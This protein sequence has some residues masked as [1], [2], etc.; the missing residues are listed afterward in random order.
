V[1]HADL[2]QRLRAYADGTLDDAEAELVRVHLATGCPECLREVFTRPVGLPRPAVVVRRSLQGIVVAALAAAAAVGAAAGLLMG[3]R[4][5]PREVADGR[6]GPLTSEVDRLRAE[7][8]H[9]EAAARACADKQAPGKEA[10]DEDA[11]ARKDPDPTPAPSPSDVA[12]STHA[13]ASCPPA[14]CPPPA[15]EGTDEAEAGAMPGWVVA[16]LASEGARVVP[17]GPGEGAGGGTGFAVWSPTRR[18]VVVSA[19]NLPLTS[20][21]ALY[22]VRVTML[23]RSTAWV[24]DVVASSRR[25]LVISV[26]LPDTAGRVA[27]VD[28]YR[29]PPGMPVLTAQ[30][31][32]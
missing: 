28:L 18:M 17:L 1:T 9:A 7:R 8:D 10:T 30:L 20:S 16:V 25:D 6:V 3:L 11:A 21:G 4:A 5:S 22:R 23:D 24:G 31:V 26:A 29:D 12:R 15:A 27:R 2:R 32:P 13:P 19:S 14:D